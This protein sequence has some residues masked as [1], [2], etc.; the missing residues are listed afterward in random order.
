MCFVD[1]NARAMRVRHIK[2]LLK[3]SKIAIH[4]I[5]AFDYHQLAPALL[6]AQCHVERGGIVMLEFFRATPRQNRA[7]TKTQMGAIVENGDIAFAQQSGNRA[8]RAAKSAVEKHGVLA[9][10]KFRDA[11][12]EFAVEIGH[13]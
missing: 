8:E 12:F 9:V 11:P 10:E 6:T 3:I 7:V 1:E 2:H 13:A 5:N 4:R